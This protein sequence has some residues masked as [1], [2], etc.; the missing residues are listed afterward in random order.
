MFESFTDIHK[1]CKRSTTYQMIHYKHAILQHKLNNIHLP[2][3]DWIDLNTQQGFTLRQTKFKIIKNTIFIVGNNL[4]S[5]RLIN[6]CNNEIN[7]RKE[8]TKMV[9]KTFK[10][11]I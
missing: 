11:H 1:T 2:Q 5:T 7:S 4:L 9:Q 8:T 6:M 10:K 3:S